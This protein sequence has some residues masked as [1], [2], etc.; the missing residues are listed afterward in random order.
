MFKRTVVIALF[1]VGAVAV[2][3]GVAEAGCMTLSGGTRY[4]AAWITG[5]E[6]C[7]VNIQGS[8]NKDAETV[9]C[10]ASAV[11]GTS[12]CLNPASKSRKGALQG[13]A[14]T[15]TVP[16]S[17]TTDIQ[18]CTKNNSICSA[19]IELDPDPETTPGLCT[20][21][22]WEFVTLTAATFTGTV[23]VCP[24][25]IVNPS[26]PVTDPNNPPSSDSNLCGPNSD[27]PLTMVENCS[28]DLTG[29]QPDDN[30]AYSCECA[31]QTGGCPLP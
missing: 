24:N 5:S 29:Y 19:T 28:V 11:Q 8:I 6:I 22:N 21:A 14:F 12:F 30:R 7:Q 13:Q 9:R 18:T 17:A 15:L 4:C 27:P 23:E 20:N 2:L 31:S 16:L 25:G 3:S 10:T 1:F 26:A